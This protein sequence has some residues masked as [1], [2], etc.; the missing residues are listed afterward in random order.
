VTPRLWQR[1]AP[2]R[3]PIVPIVP[4]SPV[5]PES[6]SYPTWS[7][8][9]YARTLYFQTSWE[10]LVVTCLVWPLDSG[11]CLVELQQRLVGEDDYTD[12]QVLARIRCE[13]QQAR[14]IL[15][16]LPTAMLVARL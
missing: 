9:R 3:D 5:N 14:Q 6:P 2:R 12:T 1:P 11:S 15:A 8:T 13:V 4:W 7:V 16:D 10:G